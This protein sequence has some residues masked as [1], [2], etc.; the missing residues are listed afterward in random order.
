MI[1]PFF[2]PHAGCPHQ[3]VFCNQKRITGKST[4]PDPSS[5]PVTIREFL[6]MKPAGARRDPVQVA[7][8]GGSFTALSREVQQAYLEQVLP[9]IASGR[10]GGVRVST[11]PDAISADGLALLQQYHVRTVE[12]GV[13]SMDDEVLERSGRGHTASDTVQAVAMLNAH[14]FSVGLQLMPGLPGDSREIFCDTVS[15]V[16]ALR[17]DVVRLYPALVIRDTPLEQLYRTRGYTPL[18]LDEAVALCRDALARLRQAGIAVIR[19]GL[20]PTEELGRPGAVVAGPFHP[21][22]RQLVESSLFLETMGSLLPRGITSGSVTFTVNPADLSSAIGQQRAN[23]RV[24][25]DRYGLDATVMTDPRV[26]R[27]SIRSVPPL[28]TGRTG[29][30]VC[31]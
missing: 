11:R 29:G 28:Q 1:I 21:A 27:G 12:L 17:P 25:R 13:Q 23:I 20:Q 7:F 15:K 8:Y 14:G 22:F 3:C 10:I 2:I 18:A 19:I 9:F 30:I 26:P 16:I 24:I 4:A 5:I 6:A 31:P